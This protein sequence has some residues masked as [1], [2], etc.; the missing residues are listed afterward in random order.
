M[1][2]NQF[3]SLMGDIVDLG[4]NINVVS[5]D[6]HVPNI[7][8][9]IHT[10]KER[11]RAK[12]NMAPFKFTPPI[13][14]VEMVYANVFWRKMFPLKGVISRTQGPADINLNRAMDFNTYE[15]LEFGDYV[16]TH[17]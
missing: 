5:R 1:A 9:Y 8:Q 17:E 16:Q 12:H 6:D 11:V 3:E 10:I 14:I 15:K 13:F 2:D 4:A 7:E